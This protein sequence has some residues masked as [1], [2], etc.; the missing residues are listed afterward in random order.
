[1]QEGMNL[2]P[3]QESKISHATGHDQKKKGHIVRKYISAFH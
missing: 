3:G 2:I 1:M